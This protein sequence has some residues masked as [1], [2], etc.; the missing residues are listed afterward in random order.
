M[1]VVSVDE[2]SSADEIVVSVVVLAVYVAV[3][4]ASSLRTVAS[5][6]HG[7]ATESIEKQKQSN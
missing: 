6:S 7:L 3:V 1:E 2:K 5:S 4:V